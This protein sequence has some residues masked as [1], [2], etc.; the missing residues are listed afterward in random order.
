MHIFQMGVV[1]FGQRMSRLAMEKNNGISF[2]LKN[3][4]ESVTIRMKYLIVEPLPLL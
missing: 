3:I 4:R 1:E 2:L